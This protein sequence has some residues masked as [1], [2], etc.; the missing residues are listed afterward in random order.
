MSSHTDEAMTQDT[1]RLWDV[2]GI[3]DRLHKAVHR[4]CKLTSLHSAETGQ[5]M[6]MHLALKA[7]VVTHP[8]LSVK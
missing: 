2:A 5:L 3:V 6:S 1:V 7:A 8:I 4:T